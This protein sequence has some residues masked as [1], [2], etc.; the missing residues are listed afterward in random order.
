MDRLEPKSTSARRAYELMAL[1][2]EEEV[3]FR[4]CYVS[5]FIDDFPCC[6][7]ESM[8][9]DF[10]KVMAALWQQLGFEPQGKKCWWEGGFAAKG[11]VLG[12]KICLDTW[13]AEVP[14]DK[15]DKTVAA[16]KGALM[17]DW[18][19]ADLVQSVIG[20]M[21]FCGQVLVP[22]D[23]R[24]VWSITAL[25]AAVVRGFAPMNSYWKEE[26]EWW[27]DLLQDWNRVALM[28]SPDWLIPTF[29]N[30]F[31]PFTDASGSEAEGGAGA[32]FG[33]YAMKFLFNATE[34]KWLPI[35]DLEGIVCVLWIWVI[36]KLWP[37]QISGLR[38]EAWCDNKSFCGA[39][40]NHKSPAPSLDF[41]LKELHKLQATYSFDLRLEYVESKKNVAAD[42]LSREAMK[43]F[44]KFM[45]TYGYEPSDIVWFDIDS[46][47]SPRSSWS[48]EMVRRRKLMTSMRPAQQPAEMQDGCGGR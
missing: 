4:F 22:G 34:L 9:D 40:N 12:I 30:E 48:S 21:G 37:E 2:C 27:V 29:A 1:D 44:Y 10:E 28:V 20:L 23:W 46:Q 42:A 31:S 39:V 11:Q 18:V 13:T 16:L 35:C 47:A 14:K 38:F 41:L 25:R 5:S 19:P 24:V 7:V 33:K 32:V 6:C 17:M 43:V 15:V 3:S 26:L 8:V 36:C 45:A